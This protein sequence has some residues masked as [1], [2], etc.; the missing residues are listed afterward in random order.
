LL[1]LLV[2]LLPL[3]AATAEAAAARK[4]AKENKVDFI[5]NLSQR[6]TYIIFEDVEQ[7]FSGCSR[8]P[9]RSPCF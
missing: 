9:S 7:F 4:N 8:E 5:D 6:I 2:L 1:E 3:P